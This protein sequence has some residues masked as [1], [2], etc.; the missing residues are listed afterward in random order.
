MALMA[1]L[2]LLRPGTPGI[3]R[4]LAAIPRMIRATLRREYDGGGRLT[5]MGVV[6]MYLLSPLDFIADALFL[7]IG[8]VGDAALVTWLFGA[9]M[10]ETERFLTWERQRRDAARSKPVVAAIESGP[11]FHR[12]R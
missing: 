8:V 7:V 5:L 3:G 4:R 1:L 12:R 6:T 11:S 9:L 2:R 10:D